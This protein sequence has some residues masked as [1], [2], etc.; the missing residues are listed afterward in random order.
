MPTA[1]STRASPANPAISAMDDGIRLRASRT[2][3][4]RLRAAMGAM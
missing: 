4:D 2:Y 3:A 1:A